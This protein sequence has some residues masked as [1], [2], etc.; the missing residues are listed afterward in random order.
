MPPST[1]KHIYIPKIQL[2]VSYCPR[3]DPDAVFKKYFG[4]CLDRVIGFIWWM[5][6]LLGAG[7]GVVGVFNFIIGLGAWTWFKNQSPSNSSV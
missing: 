4:R 6:T 1:T 2:P 7:S 3:P 5:L